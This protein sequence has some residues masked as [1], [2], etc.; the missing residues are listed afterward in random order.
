[1]NT[2][3]RIQFD[4]RMADEN[5]ARELYG[6]WDNMFVH[7]CEKVTD[8]TLQRF[9]REPYYTIIETLELD[10]GTIPQTKWDEQFPIRLHTAL[11]EALLRCFNAPLPEDKVQQQ[12]KDESACSLL[13]FFLLHGTLPWYTPKEYHNITRLFREVMARHAARFR[14]FLMQYGH[15]TSLQQ[16]LVYQLQD[17]ELEETVHLLRSAESSFII[18]YV[19][20][21]R[22][23]YKEVK[24][25]GINEANYR[26]AVWF[27]VYAWMLTDR[28][29]VF[30]RKSFLSQT[31]ASLAAR[32]NQ[33]YESLLE[34]L[35]DSIAR[36]M[37]QQVIVPELYQLLQSLRKESDENFLREARFDGRKLQLLIT[38]ILQQGMQEAI[39]R[40]NREWLTDMLKLEDSCR[41]LLSQLSE[42]E[43]VR[44]VPVIIPS[45]SDFVIRYAR[46][47]DHQKQKGALEGKVGGEFTKLKWMIIFPLILV[48]EGSAF[49]RKQFVSGVLKRIAAH[50]NLTSYDLL[51]YL[52]KQTFFISLPYALQV[53]VEELFNGTVEQN[54]NASGKTFRALLEQPVQAL[55]YLQSLDEKQRYR[56]ID[57]FQAGEKEFIISYARS[58][59]RQ[60][61]KGM[62]EGKAGGDFKHI[63][64]YFIFRVLAE[65]TG[66]RFNRRYFVRDILRNISAHYNIGYLDLLAYFHSA[67]EQRHLPVILRSVFRDLFTEEKHHLTIHILRTGTDTDRY[68]MIEWLSGKDH[69]FIRS[70]LFMLDEL[71]AFST[72]AYSGLNRRKWE[73]IE[74]LLREYPAGNIHKPTFLKRLTEQITQ[75]YHIEFSDLNKIL[76]DLVRH[77]KKNNYIPDLKHMI[78]DF[79]EWDLP[80]ADQNKETQKEGEFY[81]VKN[82][83]LVLLGPFL[84]RL[85]E[86]LKLTEGFK[87]HDDEAKVRAIHLLQYAAKG[88]MHHEEFDL[89]FN[90]LIV[91]YPENKPL[92]ASVELTEEEKQTCEQMLKAV[93]QHWPK[94]SRSS[95]MALREAFLLREGHIEMKDDHYQVVVDQKAYDILLDDITWNFRIIKC[96]WME[97][98]IEVSWR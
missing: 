26:H 34:Q 59:D 80:Q 63:K 48:Q 56:L 86:M 70:I 55:A 61:R 9:D 72:S 75:I 41:Q 29:S 53:I 52:M 42:E 85:F 35:T 58:L 16:R 20:F 30:N 79:I 12:G 88:D 33:K 43:I 23:K 89:Y 18:S 8:D 91:N 46:S 44:L 45:D 6:R 25:L 65:P 54:K 97:K 84:P 24:T 81:F 73:I 66:S 28:S 74:I 39:V 22:E 17:P 15:Y 27:V 98:R 77:N 64:W 5:F 90:K 95:I 7:T 83:G 40:R 69:K 68:R 37:Q 94:L 60:H 87:F 21:V 13:I 93:L 36:I 96:P 10:L 3:G 78:M 31:I 4:F 49:N 82:A 47:L 11:E 50:Y 92:P 2:I 38:S 57:H 32:F 14:T 19:R 51:A 71:Y 1:M 62:L 67:E 76:S